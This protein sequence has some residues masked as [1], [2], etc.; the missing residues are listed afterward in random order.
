MRPKK[1]IKPGDLSQPVGSSRGSVWKKHAG[2]EF[3][4][5]YEPD[6][7]LLIDPVTQETVAEID[8]T[9]TDNVS[10]EVV[11]DS[12]ETSPDQP[13][14]RPIVD[15]PTYTWLSERSIEGRTYRRTDRRALVVSGGDSA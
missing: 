6:G 2:P 11:I 15:Q 3:A 12:P 4:S 13:A 10:I 1:P 9:D 7:S 5:Q 8:L 14:P